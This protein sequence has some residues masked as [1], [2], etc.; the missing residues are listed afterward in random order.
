MIEDY[1]IKDAIYL[2]SGEDTL[3]LHNNYDFT[4]ITYSVAERLATLTWVRS[5]GDW[6]PATEPSQLLL[7]FHGVSCFRYMPRDPEMPFTE[8]NCLSSAGY[9]TD[10]DWCDGVMICEADPETEWLR[11]FHFQSGATVA[12]AADEAR[13]I[14]RR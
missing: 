10:E 1:T 3:D 7:E 5:S 2:V 6:V 12:I 9:W 13:A 4:E 14:I 11:A 8:D